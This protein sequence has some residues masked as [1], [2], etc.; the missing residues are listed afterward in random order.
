[1]IKEFNSLKGLLA[2]MIFIHHLSIYP[3]A[4]TLAVCMFFM[5]GGFLSAI[6]Y[7]ERIDNIQWNYTDY[8]V[9]KAIKFYPLHWI[10][11]IAAIP[12]VFRSTNHL[13]AQ[14]GVLA[15]NASLL[16]S[17]IPIQYVY[18]SFNAVSWYL[19]DTLVLV[20]LFPFIYRWLQKASTKLKVIMLSFILA[21]YALVWI[22]L[23][24]DYTHAVFYINPFFRL[25]D[26]IVGIQ[27]GLFYLNL[28]DKDAVIRHI[29]SNK[30]LYHLL[31]LFALAV[32]LVIS[33]AP[34][35]LTLH[36]VVYIIPACILLIITALNRGGY[37]QSAHLQW[38][39]SIS[40][41]FFLTHQIVL[42]YL[43]KILGLFY[44]DNI[45]IV[46]PSAFIITVIASYFLTYY[47]DKKIS[48]WLKKKINPQSTT[49]QS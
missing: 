3:G 19:S 13:L 29:E 2:L 15:V 17:L 41:A 47:F 5:I 4:G 32:L 25:L 34:M 44:L 43:H 23:P 24:S 6:G 28:K 20:A 35:E 36:S 42:R 48:L 12:L 49:A 39:G 30:I 16:H 10:L 18:F 46:A 38:F 37:L 22:Y 8:I 33:L 14:L 31:G 27:C 26:Y 40:F 21:L 11:T 45:F 1:M 7:R 9:G